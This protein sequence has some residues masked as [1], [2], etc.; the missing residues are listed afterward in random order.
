MRFAR[1]A[2]AVAGLVDR[3]GQEVPVVRVVDFDVGPADRGGRGVREAS[4][5][6]VNLDLRRAVLAD[7]GAR[8]DLVVRAVVDSVAAREVKVDLVPGREVHLRVVAVVRARKCRGIFVRHLRRFSW[9]SM[10]IMT[11]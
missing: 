6:K 10:P 5:A 1:R 7:R 9:R 11:A 2:D 8:A 4:R 3:E